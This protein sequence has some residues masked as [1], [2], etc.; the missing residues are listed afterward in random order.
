MNLSSD[1]EVLHCKHVQFSRNEGLDYEVQRF[2]PDGWVVEFLTDGYAFK[3]PKD[4]WEQK[5]WSMVRLLT[6][7]HYLSLRCIV[8]PDRAHH[9]Y[10]LVSARNDRSGFRAV[11][12]VID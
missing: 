10:E 3:G 8:Q 12:S 6:Y 1:I 2:L 7:R 4:E 5:V 9:S 11:F